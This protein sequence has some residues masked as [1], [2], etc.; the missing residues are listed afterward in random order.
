MVERSTGQT[1]Y[2]LVVMFI[3]AIVSIATAVFWFD[4]HAPSICDHVVKKCATLIYTRAFK[5]M[6]KPKLYVFTFIQI[7][8][9]I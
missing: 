4:H 1:V 7:M 3:L 5:L 2:V 8:Y 6:K 9:F